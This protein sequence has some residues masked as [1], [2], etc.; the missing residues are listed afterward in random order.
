MKPGTGRVGRSGYS[1]VE[2]TL[3]L[4]VVAIGLTATFALF[5]DGLRAARAAVDDT[6]I[7]LFA[8]Y[9][10]TTLDLTAISKGANWTM[11]N[12]R[13]FKSYALQGDE[14]D[15]RFMLKETS[16]DETAVFYW[17]P[18]YY[19]L[20]GA[21]T[22]FK[23][24]DYENFWTSAFTY[25]LELFDWADGSTY[26]RLVVWP[27]EYLGGDKPPEGEKRVFTRAIQTIRG[28]ALP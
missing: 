18:N 11:A 14:D 22:V 4:L 2:V 25:Q 6:E 21:K 12:C 16:G 26:A 7:S 8:E 9:V 24:G 1:L 10:F 17:V 13:E 3:A 27:G 28:E 15:A 20:D 23:S 19:G 5:P